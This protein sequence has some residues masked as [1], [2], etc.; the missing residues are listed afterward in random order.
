MNL[1][2]FKNTYNA[3]IITDSIGFDSPGER[4]TITENEY[5]M[6]TDLGAATKSTHRILQFCSKPWMQKL[7]GPNRFHEWSGSKDML[8]VQ[9]LQDRLDK[10]QKI[11]EQSRNYTILHLTLSNRLYRQLFLCD[12]S[13][14]PFLCDQNRI[15]FT[16]DQNSST[17]EHQPNF[18]SYC[19]R[20]P[21][22]LFPVTVLHF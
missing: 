10:V 13:K 9:A 12:W 6:L 4:R 22:A 8:S 5:P 11:W 18:F 14:T 1:G 7:H 21:V 19:V 2:K 3:V 17:L 20:S 16:C 15:P